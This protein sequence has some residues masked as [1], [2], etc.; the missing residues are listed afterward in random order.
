M[1]LQRCGVHALCW[2]WNW[3]S[4]LL[5]GLGPRSQWL[6]QRRSDGKRTSN[7]PVACG[8][9]SISSLTACLWLQ[10]VGGEDC[11]TCAKVVCDANQY[12][13]GNICTDC[14]PGST[15]SAGDPQAGPDTTCAETVCPVNQR[16]LNHACVACEAGKTRPVSNSARDSL[17]GATHAY[18]GLCVNLNVSY[19]QHSATACTS[20][21][22]VRGTS[23]VC[24]QANKATGVDTQCW[25]ARCDTAMS[26]NCSPIGTATCSGGGRHTC[27][28]ATGGPYFGDRCCWGTCSNTGICD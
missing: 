8:V 10:G 19:T 17:C 27:A 7:P 14:A 12:V 1:W 24:L 3:H 23:R 21:R 25:P 26:D 18:R 6:Q 11:G 5:A 13:S 16:V 4:Q 28:D 9:V 22:N 2:L 20:F 15:R